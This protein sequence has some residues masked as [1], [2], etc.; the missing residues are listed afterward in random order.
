[1]ADLG[2]AGASQPFKLS[3]RATKFEA[4]V[5]AADNPSAD[6]GFLLSRIPL[7]DGSGYEIWSIMMKTMFISQDLWDL[8]EGGYTEKELTF[9]ESLYVRKKDATALFFIQQAI[10]KSVFFCIAKSRTSKEAWDALQNKYQGDPEEQISWKLDDESV[11]SFPAYAN[12]SEEASW[13]AIE[14][15]YQ[16]C[17]KVVEANTTSEELGDFNNNFVYQGWCSGDSSGGFRD[18]ISLSG[19]GI[20]KDL[21]DSNNNSVSK[22]GSRGNSSRKGR[23]CRN[24]GRLN[25]NG[26][27]RDSKHLNKTK[28]CGGVDSDKPVNPNHGSRGGGGRRG[29]NSEGLNDACLNDNHSECGDSNDPKIELISSTP[30]NAIKLNE[31]QGEQEQ[32]HTAS[33]EDLNSEAHVQLQSQDGSTSGR[34]NHSRQAQKN[35]KKVRAKSSVSKQER[36]LEGEKKEFSPNKVFVGN[37]SESTT[38]EDLRK[39]FGC[40]GGTISSVVVP[41]DGDGKSKCFGFVHFKDADDAAW[42]VQ[43]LNG[44]Q[45]DNKKWK[46]TRAYKSKSAGRANRKKPADEL[47]LSCTDS[48]GTKSENS[49]D[50]SLQ[51]STAKATKTKRAGKAVKKECTTMIGPATV[52]CT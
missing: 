13:D 11:C 51:S 29:I 38:A 24:G 6:I 4:E 9:E 2:L 31:A 15:G 39:V 42:S 14:Q 30:G 5:D 19:D 22:K 7:F 43:V 17:G 37:L 32:T 16:F 25:S 12:E 40:F 36:A 35:G 3:N 8:V 23:G 45:F 50:E 48:S 52:E 26:G 21:G 33:T 44:H 41:K 18:D 27:G 49:V 28:S 34:G 46:V 20:G 1:M 47:A 10:D